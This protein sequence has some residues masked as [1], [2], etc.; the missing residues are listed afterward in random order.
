MIKTLDVGEGI[1][2]VELVEWCAQVDDLVNKDQVFAEVTTNKV[3]AETP[4]SVAGRILTL[5]GQ[6]GRV[7][8]M[9][10]ELI[11]LETGGAGNL[12]GS[13]IAVTSVVPIAAASEK[14]KGTPAAPPK[15]T[16][17]APHTLHNS[18]VPRQRRQPGGHPLA[19]P[20]V[21]QRAR[22]LGIELQFV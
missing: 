20:A 4:S 15:I 21:C 14:P 2:E 13:P 8:T 19:S 1:A 5:D 12:A 9:G 17:E 11:R 16:A 3:A 18:E 10:G 7:M 6:P 22:N